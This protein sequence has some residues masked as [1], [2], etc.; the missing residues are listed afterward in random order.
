V[1]RAAYDE[2]SGA[3]LTP[4]DLDGREEHSSVHATGFAFDVRRRYGSGAQAE[5]FQWALERLEALGLI[6]WT[7]GKADIHV[8]VSPRAAVDAG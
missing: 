3:L 6:T 8:I 4:H 1:T 5:A 2:A 7:R